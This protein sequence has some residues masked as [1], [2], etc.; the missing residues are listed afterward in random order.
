M[1]DVCLLLE[2]TYPYVAGGVSSWVYD[3]V[4]RMQD[5]SFSIVYLGAHRP[6]S[7]K[8]HYEL[9]ENV[10]DFRELYLFDYRVDPE[11]GSGENGEAV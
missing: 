2:G 8:M 5:I 3:L 6:G 11:Q 4:K 1:Q 9:P 7:K 10:V